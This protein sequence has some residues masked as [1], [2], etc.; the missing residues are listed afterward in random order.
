MEQLYVDNMYVNN[1]INTR[2]PLN[3]NLWKE[4][5]SLEWYEKVKRY[6]NNAN[7]KIAEILKS[8]YFLDEIITLKNFAVEKRKAL[9][10]T[11]NGYLKASPQCVK[12]EFLLSDDGFWDFTAH[13]VGMGEVMYTYVYDHPE[14]VLL[15]QKDYQ[16]NFEYGFDVA[17]YDIN[18]VEDNLVS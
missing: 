6:G 11:L 15:M 16:E 12:K 3:K 13:V 14:V 2:T 5:E 9:Y 17:I 18:N 8:K 7:D 4:L 10:H 1:N